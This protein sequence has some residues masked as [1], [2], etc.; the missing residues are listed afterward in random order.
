MPEFRQTVTI[1]VAVVLL[2]TLATIVGSVRAVYAP[3]DFVSCDERGPGIDS[4]GGSGCANAVALCGVRTDH[5]Y[6][7]VN[8]PP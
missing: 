2:F 3:T 7:S 4:C 1:A 6:K 5:Y 8:V